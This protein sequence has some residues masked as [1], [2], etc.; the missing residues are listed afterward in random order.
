MSLEDVIRA[1]TEAVIQLTEALLKINLPRDVVSP[2]SVIDIQDSIKSTKEKEIELQIDIAA[3]DLYKAV[4]ALINKLALDHRDEIK[5]LNQKY[6]LKVFSD[7]LIDKEN[8]EKGVTDIKKLEAYHNDLLS[9]G[10]H[11]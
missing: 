2:E 8:V 9:L 4:K 6:E 7:I 1:N 10:E 3:P 5:A 11:A